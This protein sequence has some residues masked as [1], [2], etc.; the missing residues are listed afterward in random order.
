MYFLAPD[1][2]D[3]IRII[4]DPA[5]PDENAGGVVKFRQVCPPS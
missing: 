5:V 4:D 2:P 3:I 1:F